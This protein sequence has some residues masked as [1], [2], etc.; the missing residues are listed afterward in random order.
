MEKGRIYNVVKKLLKKIYLNI[1]KINIKIKLK[2]MLTR[3]E[4]K[5]IFL[6]GSPLHGNI[7]DHAISMAER[8]LLENIKEKTVIEIPGEYYNL[9]PNYIKKRVKENDIILITGGGF[10]GSLW[11]NEENMVRNVIETFNNNRIIIMPQTVY[12]ENSEEGKRELEVS[13]SIYEYHPDLWLFVREKRSFMYCKKNLDKIKNIFLVPD[14][15]TYLDYQSPREKRSGVLFCLRKDKEKVISD[16]KINKIIAELKT[17]KLDVKN[18]TTVINKRISMKNR[19][20]VVENKL[21]EF[22]KSNLVITDR[23]HGMIFAAITATPCIAMDNLSGKVKGVYEWFKALGYIK[24]VTNIDDMINEA[25]QLM[26]NKEYNYN[27]EDFNK[28]FNIII[29]LLNEK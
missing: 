14:I 5:T 28:Q 25:K 17:K 21:M 4:K 11:L 26:S 15:V 3:N 18:T 7:G 20:K 1:K 9:C 29:K 19:K 2:K 24:F 13:K 22:K 16:E 23:L 8:K 6:I 27:N 12:F 10:I